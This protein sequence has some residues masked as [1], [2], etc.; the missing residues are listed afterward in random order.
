M[1]K[2][3]A[4]DKV[5]IELMQTLDAMEDRTSG[6]RYLRFEPEF[7]ALRQ[8]VTSVSICYSNSVKLCLPITGR[9]FSETL[10]ATLWTPSVWYGR[11]R[12][13]AGVGKSGY[14]FAETCL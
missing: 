6:Q 5:A 8:D 7:V 10:L 1:S 3:R 12:A 4:S 9:G 11:V 14:G 2:D 13:T